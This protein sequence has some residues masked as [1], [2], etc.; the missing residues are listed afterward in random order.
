MARFGLERETMPFETT[1]QSKLRYCL[2]AF[3]A[4]GHERQDDPVGLMSANVLETLQ[5]EP[6]TDIFFLSH[7]WQGDVPSG[8]RQ[9]NNWIDAMAACTADLEEMKQTRPGFLPLIIGLHW[10]SLAWGEEEFGGG[11]GNPS[12]GLPTADPL[13][14][15]VEQ[16]AERLDATPE[17]RAALRTIINS[18]MQE[19]APDEL[20]PEVREA[21]RLLDVQS[22][23]SS[24][25]EGADPGADR[26]PFD[27]DKVFE[28]AQEQLNFAGFNL[29]GLLAP[30][31][32]LTFWKMKD[33]AKAFGE[34]GAFD[35]L[36]RIQESGGV[37]PRI[38]F[39]GHSFGCIVVSAALAGPAG[40]GALRRPVNSL[41]LVQ[42]ALSLWS[43]CSEIPSAK[44]RAGFF[45][46]IIQ[47]NK[48]NGPIITT[49][50]SLDTA[51]GRFYPL[52][53]G[54]RGD[55]AFAPGRLPKYGGVGTWGA[56]GPGLTIV[57]LQMQPANVPYDFKRGTLYNLES[58]AYIREGGGASGAHNDIARPEVAHAF[59]SAV[60]G[61]P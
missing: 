29:G 60:R 20:P 44:G 4:R 22:S 46:S 8:R 1:P 34:T 35:L 12:F 58:S 42:G 23:L 15:M 37:K 55:V 56:R 27:P 31:R 6:V 51:V 19:T 9:Y 52:G 32:T 38:H 43:F 39:M 7:G 25:G 61:A 36:Q 21:Y 40:R 3:D 57:D 41:A 13:E 18:A 33:R 48:V 14:A 28:A 50:S 47:E 30:L 11:D 26:E 54:A 5:R 49:M 2:I 53:A 10:P 59:W 24:E 16:Y 45:R 17:M